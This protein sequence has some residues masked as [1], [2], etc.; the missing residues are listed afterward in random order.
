MVDSIKARC[1]MVVVAIA[2][3]VAA[4][5]SAP[6]TIQTAADGTFELKMSLPPGTHHPADAL[7][8]VAT[9]TYDGLWIAF[10]GA[11]TTCTPRPVF[12]L[13]WRPRALDQE[14]WP[15][16]DPR[17]RLAP[18]RSRA[19]KPF[20]A[21]STGGDEM[22]EGRSLL[23]RYMS[24]DTDAVWRQIRSADGRAQIEAQA[25]AGGANGEVGRSTWADGADLTDRDAGSRTAS[26]CHGPMRKV[27]CG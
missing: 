10:V 9:L 26:A 5:S 1:E 8:I 2:L 23:A 16:A 25:H 19:R 13:R 4:C 7:D 11:Q 17:A 20:L 12:S 18:R 15:R 21:R 6:P 3:A 24:G 22:I 27:T 14:L